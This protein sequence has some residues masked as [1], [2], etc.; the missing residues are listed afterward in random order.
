MRLAVAVAVLLMTVPLSAQ[1]SR[2]GGGGPGGGDDSGGSATFSPFDLL[3]DELDLKDEKQLAA[4]RAALEGAER[5]AAALFQELIPR[6]QDLLNV[7]TNRSTDPAPAQAYTATVTK[8]I[9]LETKVFEEIYAQLTP[10][11]KQKAAKGFDR[12]EE[13]FKDSLSTSGAGRADA[14]RGGPG[15]VPGRGMSPQGGGR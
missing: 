5:E 10:K 2:G 13:L 9:A 14:G 12:L 6:R 15:G 11:Q 7:E 4:V 3:V 8:L 1:R